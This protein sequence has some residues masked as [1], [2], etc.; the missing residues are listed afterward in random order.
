MLALALDWLAGRQR[1]VGEKKRTTD[2]AVAESLKRAS[3]TRGYMSVYM[4]LAL[5]L[6][7]LGP[8]GKGRY[9]C[10]SLL[11]VHNLLRHA[12]V[13][14]LMGVGSNRILRRAL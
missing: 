13:P 14:R 4:Y 3:H 7:G 6:L 2:S 5:P 8:K 12:K 10:I 1:T 9:L 11:H